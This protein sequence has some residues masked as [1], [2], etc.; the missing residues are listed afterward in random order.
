MCIRKWS[1]LERVARVSDACAALCPWAPTRRPKLQISR[2]GSL[3]PPTGACGVPCGVVHRV[4]EHRQGQLQELVAGLDAACLG[5]ELQ[6]PRRPQGRA[7][8]LE[9]QGAAHALQAVRGPRLALS[10]YRPMARPVGSPCGLRMDAATQRINKP[11]I[12]LWKM[13][14]ARADRPLFATS[15]VLSLPPHA[16]AAAMGGHFPARAVRGGAPVLCGGAN[17]GAVRQ[18]DRRAGK[19]A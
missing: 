5:R 4:A 7:V 16:E 8:E 11:P 15:P 10:Q 12:K 3:N 18:G 1:L 13:R 17:R 6:L 2:N 19:G 9:D 14:I